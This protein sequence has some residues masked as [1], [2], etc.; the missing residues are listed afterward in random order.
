MGLIK[1]FGS[2]S[3]VHIVKKLENTEKYYAPGILI[4]VENGVGD[5]SEA[6]VR[7]NEN[8]CYYLQLKGKPLFQL[9]G[10]E[11]FCPTCE[12]IVRTAYQLEQ[13][14]DFQ[15]DK[16][17]TEEIGLEEIVSEITPLLKLLESGF[18]CLWDTKLYPTD[19]NGNLFWDYP[20]NNNVLPGSC[21]FYFGDGK[22]GTCVPH[23]MIA[24]QPKKLLNM[25]RVNYYRA[26]SKCKAIAYYMDGNITALIDG[27]HKAMAAAIDHRPCNS[28]VISKCLCGSRKDSKGEMQKYISANDIY[29]FNDELPDQFREEKF[30][31]PNRTKE[32]KSTGSFEI[33]IN[34]CFPC[35]IDTKS[36]ADFYP[37]VKEAVSADIFGP[38]TDEFINDYLNGEKIIGETDYCIFLDALAAT[39]DERLFKVIDY[40]LYHND[41][42]DYIL[43]SLEHLLE[44]PHTEELENYL[45]SYM[46]EIEGEHREIGTYIAQNLW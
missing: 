29:I 22:W 42:A 45:I 41:M 16:I 17:N 15:L 32:H 2:G 1:L 23:F 10:D 11:Y 35:H 30:Q 12:K 20:N 46:I 5:L 36:L 4:F 9:Q 33:N 40:T 7:E 28:I 26:K 44:F 19:G 43:P 3:K 24:T 14:E 13:T 21:V 38:I 31:V 34:D 39:K 27:H 6:H 37:S 25:E 18:Y 8:E